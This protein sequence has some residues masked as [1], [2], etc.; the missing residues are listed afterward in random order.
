MLDKS[1]LGQRYTCHECGTKYYD[2]NR[3]SPKCPDCNADPSEAPIRDISLIL[4]NSSSTRSAP[5]PAKPEEAEE[6]TEQEFADVENVDEIDDVDD[7]GSFG[8]LDMDD[9]G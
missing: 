9:E 8:D 7:L 2:L 5:A 1:K 3:P 4:S 6:E